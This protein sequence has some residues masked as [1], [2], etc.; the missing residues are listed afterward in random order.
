MLSMIT[1]S[2]SGTG[3]YT[4]SNYNDENSSN[5]K[6]NTD[7]SILLAKPLEWNFKI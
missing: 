6:Y 5:S 7:T 3:N 2:Y 1:N 4:D